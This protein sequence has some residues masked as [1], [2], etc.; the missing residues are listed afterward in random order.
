MGFCSSSLC[1]LVNE[2]VQRSRGENIINL[3]QKKNFFVEFFF[4]VDPKY[5]EITVKKSLFTIVKY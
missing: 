5:L 1:F 2:I 4:L 3:D